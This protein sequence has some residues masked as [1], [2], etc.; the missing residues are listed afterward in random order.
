MN[1]ENIRRAVDDQLAAHETTWGAVF[2]E[3]SLL[4]PAIT[5]LCARFLAQEADVVAHA[6]DPERF[7]ERERA[8]LAW[9]LTIGWDPDSADDALFDRLRAHFSD[10]QLVGLG[11]FI[12]ITLG[13]RNWLRTLST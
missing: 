10:A 8:A 6:D 12:G 11:T 9:A 5:E 3:D 13:Q 4:D 7:D 1:D 2:T